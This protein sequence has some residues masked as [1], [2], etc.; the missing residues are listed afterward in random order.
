MAPAHKGTDRRIERTR[1][2]LWEALVSLMIE[3][4]YESTT[5]QEII[6]RANVGRATF[7]AHFSNKHALLDSGLENLRVL[8]AS[9]RSSARERL[10]FSLPLLEHARSHLPLYGSIVGRES[11][12]Y[13]LRKIEEIVAELVDLDLKALGV[14]RAYNQRALAVRFVSGAFMSVLTWWAEGGAKQA[15]QEVDELFRRLVAKGVYAEFGSRL[16]A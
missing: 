8:L 16:G 6:D 4:G 14:A 15:P 3:K 10:A 7:Y 11:G 12:W 13:V 2:E 5:V 1:K 9:Q